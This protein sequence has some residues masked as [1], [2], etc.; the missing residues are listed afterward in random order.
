MIA[1]AVT[2]GTMPAGTVSFKLVNLGG[3]THKLVVLPLPPAGARPAQ[4]TPTGRSRA[5]QRR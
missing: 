5:G 4:P 3:I 2:P 1:I